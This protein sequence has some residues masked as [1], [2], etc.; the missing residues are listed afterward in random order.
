MKSFKTHL[1]ESKLVSVLEMNDELFDAYIDNLSD[2]ELNELEEGIVVQSSSVAK[3]A[4]GSK[5][6]KESANRVSASVVQ[7]PHKRNL[8]KFKRRKQTVRDLRKQKQTSK[9][10]QQNQRT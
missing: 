8:L 3:V 2:T 10:Q 1:T 4:K 5:C 7:M 9:Q 6:S